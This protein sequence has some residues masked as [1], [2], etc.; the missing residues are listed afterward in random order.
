MLGRGSGIAAVLF[1]DDVDLSSLSLDWVSRV[2]LLSG[3]GTCPCAFL[4][5]V[6]GSPHSSSL[7][8][9]LSCVSYSELTLLT[10]SARLL[11]ANLPVGPSA[12]RVLG[13]SFLLD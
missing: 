4:V 1:S 7:R 13:P 8:L 2:S 12:L 5:V 9:T 6:V 11:T 10:S 3:F